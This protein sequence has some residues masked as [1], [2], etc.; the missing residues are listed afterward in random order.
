MRALEEQA[1]LHTRHAFLCIVGMLD[2]AGFSLYATNGAP[3]A[4]RVCFELMFGHRMQAYRLLL[5]RLS[6]GRARP[7]VR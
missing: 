2:A 6:V 1:L 4:V 3:P 7:F 5:L